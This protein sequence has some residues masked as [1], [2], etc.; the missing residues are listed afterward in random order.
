M[1]V[2]YAIWSDMKRSI[3]HAT[4][5]FG[6]ESNSLTSICFAC[7]FGQGLEF[8]RCTQQFL[9]PDHNWQRDLV[10]WESLL[11]CDFQ[12]KYWK[13][14]TNCLDDLRWSSRS[15]LLRTSS[16]LPLRRWPMETMPW[17]RFKVEFGHATQDPFGRVRDVSKSSTD[18]EEDLGD[19]CLDL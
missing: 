8:P 11:P 16:V 7:S 18:F 15:A 14:T 10:P 1:K 9:K 3:C 4:L 6:K 12:G 19:V 2:F 5:S 13:Q 17:W